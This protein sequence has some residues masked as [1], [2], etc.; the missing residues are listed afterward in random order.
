M[1]REPP[2]EAVHQLDLR[3]RRAALLANSFWQARFTAII[4]DNVYGRD[5]L[6]GFVDR[7]PARPLIVVMLSPQDHAVIERE[8]R[9]GSR[10]YA[11]W[12]RQGGLDAAVAEFQAYIA[13]TPRIGLWLDTTRQA[14]ETTVQ[15]ILDRAW[16][17]GRVA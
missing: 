13:H 5:E 1:T 2:A 6:I 16:T 3:Y 12:I 8:Q 10:A 14:P 11:G 17:E 9:R 4:A 15:I 7:V